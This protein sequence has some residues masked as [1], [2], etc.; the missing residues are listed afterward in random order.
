[1]LSSNV[2]GVFA[3]ASICCVAPHPSLPGEAAHPIKVAVAVVLDGKEPFA[4]QVSCLPNS[5]CSL[6]TYDDGDIDLEITVYSGSQAHGDLS[7][8][9]SPDPC[10]FRNYR[11]RIDFTGRRATIEILSGA[12]D[13]GT[14]I[15]LV[16]R[17]RP[18]IGHV[19]IA[20]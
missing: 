7:I 9:Y 6:A 10:S 16:I 11:S 1:M 12:A 15:P 13:V 8:S 18:E 19:L 3:I 5:P 4:A 14:A 17:Q 20:Y 2:F